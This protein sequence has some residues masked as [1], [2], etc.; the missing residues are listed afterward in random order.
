MTLQS[1]VLLRQDRMHHASRGLASGVLRSD[2]RSEIL[3]DSSGKC[4]GLG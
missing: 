3:G 1:V 4:D 2:H